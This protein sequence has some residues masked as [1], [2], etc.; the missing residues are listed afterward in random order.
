[1]HFAAFHCI[2]S[3]WP[4]KEYPR[5]DR[6]SPAFLGLSTVTSGLDSPHFLL[7]DL[8]VSLSAPFIQIYSQQGSQRGACGRSPHATP[9]LGIR[10][11]RPYSACLPVTCS[12]PL[13]LSPFIALPSVGLL[14]GSPSP[15]GP[16]AAGLSLC[17]VRVCPE[18]ALPQFNHLICFLFFL[19]WRA[20][21]RILVP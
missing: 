11:L 1:M 9:E 12:P 10:V 14:A 20:A 2:S 4:L 17:P 3:C 16:A 8:L 13:L 18:S 7:P 5:S 6:S 15:L 21:C 19:P